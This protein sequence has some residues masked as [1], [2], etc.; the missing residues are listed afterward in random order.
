MRN[1]NPVGLTGGIA[2]GKST[3]SA[4]LA[5]CGATFID[6]DRVSRAVVEPG[7]PGLDAVIDAFGDRFLTAEG[8]LDRAAL[9]QLIFSEPEARARLNAI[10]HPRMA[11]L[12]AHRIAEALHRQ[13][14]LVVYDAALLIEMGQAD[15][16]RPLVVVHVPAATQLARLRAR[17]GLTAAEAQARVSSQ[18]PVAEKVQLADHVIENG[19]TR[20]QTHAQVAEV[21]A[22]LTAPREHS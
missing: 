12:T 16:F 11:T 19:G 15:R 22:R 13:P 5:E 14:P 2:C 21:F 9:G 6:A 17:D 18:M 3:V 8:R 4:M 1:S 10:L 7:T 20:A